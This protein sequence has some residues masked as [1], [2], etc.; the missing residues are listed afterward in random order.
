MRRIFYFAILFFVILTFVNCAKRGNPSGGSK[1]SI[2][3]IIIKYKPENYSINFTDDEIKIYFN[4]YIKLID[5]NKELII[6]PP[7]KY[8]PEISPLS[9]GKFI[10]IKIKDTLK[11]STTYSFNFGKSIVDY[12]EG[13]VLKYFKYSFMQVILQFCMT[14]K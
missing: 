12:T 7:L 3:P 1:D 2:P 5:I 8:Q 10:K 9:T 13:N 4:E 11:K 14:V 6:S